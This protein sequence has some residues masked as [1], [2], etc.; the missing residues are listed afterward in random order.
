MTHWQHIGC[1]STATAT[2]RTAGQNVEPAH[3]RHHHL[4]FWIAA[5][6]FLVNMGFSAVPTPLYSLF[7][8]RDHFS[9]ITLTVIY[10]VYA[11]GVIV[12]LLLAGHISDWVG[13]K[14]LF[15]PALLV[16]VVSAGVFI[17]APSLGGLLVARVLSGVS[18][19]LSTATATAYLAELHGHTRWRGSQ[20][21][22]MVAIAVNLGGI[23]FGP[24]TAGVLAQ[25]APMPLRLPFIVF[26]ATLLVLSALVAVSPETVVPPETKV[27]WRPQRIAVPTEARGQFFAAC[28]A[29]ASTFA[30]FG[31]FNSVAPALLAGTL[32]RTSHA[33]AGLVAF[34][35]FATAAASQIML[36]RL[37]P[38]RLLLI[39]PLVLI[40]G[41]G[42]LIGG[43]WAPSLALFI[44]GG[45]L[46]G[47]GGGLLFRACLLT[48]ASTAPSPAVRGEVLAGFFV[49]AYVGLSLPVIGLGIATEHASAKVVMIY[50]LGVIAAAI[51]V[52][53]RA[54]A[55]TQA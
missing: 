47:A 36:G 51:L 38:T 5:A 33:L 20:R 26:A 45:V 50:F 4:G 13:R 43:M 32:G 29:G 34:V 46:I 7:Q 55:R 39:G 42:L 30:V 22:D 41:M 49:G 35:V 28:L 18:V 21:A 27:A 24:L 2:T 15:V 25:W 44:A 12:S 54:A 17:A 40:P 23:G 9:T 11:V 1:M 31:V 14:Q 48:A 52:S 37:N 16:N 6:A 3:S 8:R 10:A 53:T 19:G